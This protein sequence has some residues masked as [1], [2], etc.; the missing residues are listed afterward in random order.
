M[1]RRLRQATVADAEAEVA[2]LAA[3]CEI[4]AEGVARVTSITMPRSADATA[5]ASLAE[6]T[7]AEHGLVARVQLSPRA[8]TILIGPE[9]S[10]G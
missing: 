8:V 1:I 4:V 3:A 6:R 7:A 2:H 9:H 5:L 10:D